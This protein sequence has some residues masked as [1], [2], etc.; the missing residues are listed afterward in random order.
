MS[1]WLFALVPII[2]IVLA[3]LLFVS[4]I[5]PQIKQAIGA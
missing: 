2:G 4:Y 5:I 3:A 1:G